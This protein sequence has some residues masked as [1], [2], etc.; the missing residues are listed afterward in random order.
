M[1]GLTRLAVVAA[2]ATG[3]LLAAAPASAVC[4]TAS[5][6]NLDGMW[7]QVCTDPGN[8]VRVTCGREELGCDE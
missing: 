4:E 5:V 8:G 1:T 2:L 7:V 3:P 6:L